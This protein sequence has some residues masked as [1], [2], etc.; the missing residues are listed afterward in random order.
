MA[1]KDFA[2]QVRDALNLPAAVLLGF[3][4]RIEDQA[5][6]PH[7]RIKVAP[8]AR[9]LHS[10]LN[11]AEKDGILRRPD[12]CPPASWLAIRVVKRDFLHTGSDG[13]R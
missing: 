4:E 12:H 6:A 10:G 7:P 11:V 13:K 5:A 2:A 8:G 1:V 3:L 9:Q